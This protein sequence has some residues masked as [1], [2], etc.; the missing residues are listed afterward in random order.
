MGIPW[1]PRPRP[2]HLTFTEGSQHWQEHPVGQVPSFDSLGQSVGH[3]AH[4]SSQK[5]PLGTFL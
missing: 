2:V 4:G 1:E 3:Q 5:V